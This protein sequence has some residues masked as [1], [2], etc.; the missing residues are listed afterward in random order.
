MLSTRG[1]ARISASAPECTPTVDRDLVYVISPHADLV[2][3]ESATGKERWR[4]NL[5]GDFDGKKPNKD[6]WGYSESVLI[7]GDRLVLIGP[8]ELRYRFSTH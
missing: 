8:T 6:K 2:C 7:D 3:C 5:K 1:L 4:K